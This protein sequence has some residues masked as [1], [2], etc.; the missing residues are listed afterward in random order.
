MLA[1]KLGRTVAEL[2]A[3]LSNA[4]YV[5]WRAFHTWRHAMQEF[6]MEKAKAER[7]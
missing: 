7:G 2:R 5:E 3:S 6:E 4:E 1:E